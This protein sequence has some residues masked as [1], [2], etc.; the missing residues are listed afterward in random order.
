MVQTIWSVRDLANVGAGL[1]ARPD[2]GDFAGKGSPLQ[3]NPL[4]V[5]LL[6]NR[7]FQTSEE[8]ESFLYPN[9][10]RLCNP[11]LMKGMR[12]AVDRLERARG[13]HEKVLIH[14]DYDVD[15]VT[16]AAILSLALEKCKI[17]H[18]T[19]LPDRAKDGYGVSRQA[20]EK[21]VK[22][23]VKLLITVDCGISAK[24]EIAIA[25]KAGIDAIVLDHH[26]LPGGGLPPADMIL[27]P[28]Q[29]D[30]LYPFKELSAGGLAF[31]L[32]QALLGPQAFEFFDLATLSTV[33]D[34]APLREE[35]RILV[36]E[37]LRQ[38]S[39]RKRIGIKALSETA[40]LRASEVK[41]SHVGFIF[42][43][44]IN[45][46]GRMGSAL[47]AL[48]LLLTSS[49]REAKSLALILEEENRRRQQEERRVVNEAVEQVERTVNFSRD[50]VLV[51]ADKGWHQGVIGIVASRLVER[52]HRPAL[53]ISLAQEK[54]KGSG[55]SIRSFHLV[56]AL[57]AAQEHLLEF[58][59]HEQAAGFSIEPEQIPFLRKKLNE[60]SHRTYP[61]E[62]FLKSIDIDLEISLA[63]LS[64]QFLRELE[65]LEPHGI[66]NP[67]PVFLTRNLLIH[68]VMPAPE[69]SYQRPKI[70]VTDGSFTYEVAVP[71]RSR[72]PFE[73]EVGVRFDLVYSLS[74]KVWQG[75]ERIVLE[76]KDAKSPL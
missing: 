46:S 55:R 17:A 5:H 38:L 28:L 7:G 73:F 20:I 67:K 35:N 31:K 48:R 51:V 22:D 16:G 69:K 56:K 19:F 24:E 40:N 14:G 49:L 58:G 15:G 42:G 59:G 21:A 3:L 62:I 53:V 47:T 6:A 12:E 45:A 2:M 60:Y 8:I 9:Q 13:N 10:A 65:L 41:T 75:E 70:W 1:H 61:G 33:A 18:E 43:P 44:R 36:K 54:G 66:G 68:R 57:E 34:L 76:A 23:G 52:Y 50:R 74:R 26:Q 4:F 27:N 25:R 39:A 30:C 71:E 72:I 29:E 11:F 64:S 63:E 37:G 32:A